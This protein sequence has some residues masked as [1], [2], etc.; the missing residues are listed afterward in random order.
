MRSERIVASTTPAP[1]AIGSV[2]A[3]WR[4]VA[5]RANLTRSGEHDGLACSIRAT[6]PDTTPVDID[7]PLP[8]R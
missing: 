4:A 6:E 2:D 8:L 7:V 5:V 1:T 3:A